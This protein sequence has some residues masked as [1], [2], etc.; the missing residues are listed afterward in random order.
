MVYTSNTSTVQVADVSIDL[1]E[2]SL[3]S[4]TSDDFIQ[5][6]FIQP[7]HRGGFCDCWSVANLRVIHWAYH[8]LRYTCMHCG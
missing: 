6:R 8:D 7:E 2:K 3:K 4:F 5:F 1:D